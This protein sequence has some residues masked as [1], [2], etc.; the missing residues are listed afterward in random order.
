MN[1]YNSL[2][3]VVDTIN[4]ELETL[5]SNMR[6]TKQLMVARNVIAQ[7]LKELKPS[8]EEL[9]ELMESFQLI[10]KT[11]GD[12]NMEKDEK[13]NALDRIYQDL[14]EKHAK[15]AGYKT[16]DSIKSKASKYYLKN[17]IIFCLWVRLYDSHKDNLFFYYD[18]QE[19][20]KTN[21]FNE[22][23][24]SILKSQIIKT[25]G[26]SHKDYMVLTRG[27][28]YLTDICDKESRNIQEILTQYDLKYIA[29]I[30]VPLQQRIDR[31]RA[32]FRN[33]K[34]LSNSVLMIAKNIR[35]KTWENEE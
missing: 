11:L 32:Y 8:Y 23:L 25:H 13:R 30:K 17:E 21:I 26:R 29:E 14:F 18:I 19:L 24:F 1:A 12:V 9:N 16:R 5:D 6:P 27:S 34:I 28:I 31:E 22:Q 7:K 35:E 10:R 33:S 20:E 4:F 15:N 3:E 2:S